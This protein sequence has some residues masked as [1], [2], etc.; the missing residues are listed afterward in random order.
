MSSGGRAPHRGGSAPPGGPP[1]RGAA[2]EFAALGGGLTV[3]M[4]AL[5]RV[6]NWAHQLR[7]FQALYAIAFGFYALAVI[8]LPRYRSLPAAGLLVL[9]VA[10]AGRAAL[11]PVPPTLSDDVYRYVWE[12]RVIRHGGNPY[13]TSPASAELAPLRDTVIW[14]RV[15]HPELATIYPPLAEAAFA[16]VTRVSESAAGMKAWIVLS[17]LAVAAVLLRWARSAGRARPRRWSTPGI[18]WCWWSTPAAGTTSRPRC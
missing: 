2:L 18:R 17:D 5:A 15:N 11:L 13:R 6:P 12:G 10:L 3:V 14:P 7:E 9:A 1:A 16:V 4:C 8:R